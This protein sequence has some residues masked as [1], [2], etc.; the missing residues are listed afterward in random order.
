MSCYT[1]HLSELFAAAGIEHNRQNARWVDGQIRRILG[2]HGDGCPAV[3]KEVKAW[4]ADA[5]KYNKLAVG[6]REALGDEAR[7]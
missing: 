5:E 2:K 4:L 7:L 3:S 6:L 1:R